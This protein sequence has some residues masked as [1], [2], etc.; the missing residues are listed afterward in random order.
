MAIIPTWIPTTPDGTPAQKVNFPNLGTGTIQPIALS[1][2]RLFGLYAINTSGAAAY[3][4]IFDALVANIT[5]GTTAPDEQLL[6]ASAGTAY[7]LLPQDGL[8][9]ANA[10]S[11]QSTTAVSGS[12]GSASGV[13]VYAMYLTP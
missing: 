4:Q 1:T 11:V 12:T 8:Y 5:L 9:F 3:V 2:A 6:V 13:Y 10:I 7:L